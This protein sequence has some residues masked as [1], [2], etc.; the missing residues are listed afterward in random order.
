MAFAVSTWARD[1]AE[2]RKI[3]G[4]LCRHCVLQAGPLMPEKIWYVAG[5]C[6]IF[7]G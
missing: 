4:T 3:Q 7:A 6:G 5:R 2:A 1:P